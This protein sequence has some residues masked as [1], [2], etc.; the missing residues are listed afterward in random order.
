MYE[1]VPEL[2]KKSV[3][4]LRLI[5][6]DWTFNA[7]CCISIEE[8]V[9][10]A[11]W[12]SWHPLSPSINA[13]FVWHDMPF[14]MEGFWWN[15]P[16]ISTMSMWIAE[17][18]SK[19]MGSEVKVTRQQPQKSGELDSSWTTEGIWDKTYAYAYYAWEITWLCFQGHG[20]IVQGHIIHICTSL[21][22][23]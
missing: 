7:S 11:V 2:S 4:I 8:S 23:I 18:T 5:I 13:H 16:Q 10:N 17:K 6:N 20:V 3:H 14:L 21:C 12:S 19:V 22:M 15:L 1:V 9:L